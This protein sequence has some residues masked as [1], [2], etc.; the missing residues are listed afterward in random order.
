MVEGILRLQAQFE[1]HLFM[2]GGQSEFLQDGQ[3]G[4]EEEGTAHASHRPR[5]IAQGVR[6]WRLEHVRIGKVV[7]DPIGFGAAAEFRRAYE[8]GPLGAVSPDGSTSV[9]DHKL[10]REAFMNAPDTGGLPAA[11]DEIKRPR[12]LVEEGSSPSH[13]Q[14]IAVLEFQLLRN[15]ESREAPFQVRPVGVLDIR[16]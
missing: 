1:F 16:S 5:R 3:V 6:I 4:V 13:R 7:I 15:V 8:I 14:V 12:H 10:K 11:H 9:C 2:A